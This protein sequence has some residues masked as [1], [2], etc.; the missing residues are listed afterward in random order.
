MKKKQ[1]YYVDSN[2]HDLTTQKSVKNDESNTLKSDKTNQVSIDLFVVS[3]MINN[4]S[5]SISQ[6]N[7]EVL[8]NIINK[9]VSISFRI[10]I[11]QNANSDLIDQ[12]VAKYSII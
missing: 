8:L 2:L 12:I 5:E 11:H 3:D 4:I 9:N 6:Q 10:Q 7:S 1:C